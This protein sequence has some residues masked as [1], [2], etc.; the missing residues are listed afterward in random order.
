MAARPKYLLALWTV[1]IVWG[2]TYFAIKISVRTL[3]PLVSAGTR[4]LLAG[5]LMAAF[6]A[7]RGKSLR[8]SRRELG[9][10]AILG[11][12]LLGIGVGGTTPAET[13]IDSSS[14]AMI[15]G[16]VPLQVI[17]WRTLSR[18]RVALATRLSVV[19]GLVGLGLV[20][21][22]GS[23]DGSASALGLAIMLGASV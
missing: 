19:V 17:L 11:I 23:R 13:H 18:E 2:S 4:F 14:A 22:P 12:G 7:W 21:L 10:A 6:L 15:A 20:V 1:Y 16:S 3:P 8:V 9:A 5:A